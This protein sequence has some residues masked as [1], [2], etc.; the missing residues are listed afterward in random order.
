MRETKKLL[1]ALDNI[2]TGLEDIDTSISN[3]EGVAD[4][5]QSMDRI[6]KTLTMLVLFV[7]NNSR[8][9]FIPSY[10]YEM[11]ESQKESL[12]VKQQTEVNL[13]RIADAL[14]KLLKTT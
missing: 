10:L 4:I 6:D 2:Q 1:E 11:V 3:L 7:L 9:E 12:R 8:L 5:C 13:Q 14:E